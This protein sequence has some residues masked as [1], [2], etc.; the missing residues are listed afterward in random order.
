[1]Q[2][3]LAATKFWRIKLLKRSFRTWV[4][5]G[6]MMAQ[7]H[8][9]RYHTLVD[10]PMIKLISIFRSRKRTLSINLKRK[11][12]SGWKQLAQDTLKLADTF[13]AKNIRNR[14]FQIIS[15]SFNYRRHLLPTL[16][17]HLKY[18]HNDL[19]LRAFLVL[20][21]AYKRRM[22]EKEKQ[23][24]LK[25]NVQ[26]FKKEKYFYFW[27]DSLKRLQKLKRFTF[28][29]NY[30]L[31]KSSLYRWQT[32]YKAR[33]SKQRDIAKLNELKMRQ[34]FIKWKLK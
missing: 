9:F 1:M 22:A 16:N 34:L 15:H 23:I 6:S 28:I 26:I 3:W 14:C 2:E 10:K 12:F 29:Q 24:Q 13:Y 7:A 32:E 21:T 20:K 27:F 33:Q 17:N 5:N 11:I 30:K 18:Y 19:Q 25:S 31:Q 8:V 4:K